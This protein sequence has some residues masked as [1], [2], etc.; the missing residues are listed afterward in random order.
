MIHQMIADR[1]KRL[2]QMPFVSFFSPEIRAA[3]YLRNAP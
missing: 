3:R 2:E 1:R